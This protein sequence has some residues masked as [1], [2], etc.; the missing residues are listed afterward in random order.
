MK[1]LFLTYIYSVMIQK[2][3]ALGKTV[4]GKESSSIPYNL[5]GTFIEH[6]ETYSMIQVSRSHPNLTVL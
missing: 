1:L 3:Q 2:K 6:Q 4:S 5:L